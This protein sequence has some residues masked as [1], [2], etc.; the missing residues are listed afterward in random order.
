MAEGGVK[1]KRFLS[2]Y[3]LTESVVFLCVIA[4]VVSRSGLMA[5]MHW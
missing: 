3:L 4:S 1:G 5:M 2:C